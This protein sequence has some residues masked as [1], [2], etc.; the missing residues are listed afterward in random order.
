MEKLYLH[1]IAQAVGGQVV[2][3]HDDLFCESVVIDSR[4]VT[5]NALFVGIDGEHVDGNDYALA[6]FEIGASIVLV[7]KDVDLIPSDNKGLIRVPSSEIAL[8]D[9]SKYYKERFLKNT[10]F[11]GITGSVGKT[12]VKDLLAGMLSTK[13]RVFKTRGNYNNELGLP[14]MLFAMDESYDFA[15]LE[16]GMSDFGEIHTLVNIVRPELAL[17]TTIGTSHIE[18]LKSRENILKAKLEIADFFNEDNKLFLNGDDELLAQV[19]GDYPIIRAGI[20]QGDYRAKNINLDTHQGIFEVT[21]GEEVLGTMTL[22]LP[23]MHNVTNGILSFACAHELGIDIEDLA[24]LNIER[25]GMRMEEQELNHFLLINDA[26]NAS[27][28]S[29]QAGLR[30]LD[31]YT[32]R[33]VAILGDMLELGDFAPEAHRQVGQVA[34]DKVDLVIAAGNHYLDYKEGFGSQDFYGYP[35]FEDAVIALPNIVEPGDIIYLKASRGERFERFI[36][37]LERI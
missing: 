26:Y 24:S 23:G 5:D 36:N 20:T 29:A 6:A 22:K 34:R 32:G 27:P 18:I 16:M 10:R 17:I 9:L 3:G 4:K 13:Y 12:T 14:L 25:T 30:A 21:K 19:Q 2:F 37:A 1:E 28:E 11:I 8:Q 35:T 15:V 7:E 31:G 33:K